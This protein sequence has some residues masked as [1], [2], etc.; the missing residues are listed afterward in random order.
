MAG[1]LWCHR[2]TVKNDLQGDCRTGR[3]ACKAFLRSGRQRFWAAGRRLKKAPAAIL[4]ER[5]PNVKWALQWVCRKA[6]ARGHKKI[7]FLLSMENIKPSSPCVG[8][9]AVQLP[10]YHPVCSPL[11]RMFQKRAATCA[12]RNAAHAPGVGRGTPAPWRRIQGGFAAGRESLAAGGTVARGAFSLA[13]KIPPPVLALA[14]CC[15]LQC[16]VGRALFVRPAA[17]H[18]AGPQATAIIVGKGRV[19]K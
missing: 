2:G 7:F 4:E 1:A 3:R 17:A 18:F 6:A 9:K 13:G 15:R 19:V 12:R 5:R 16:F 14:L 11:E 8:T 10:R